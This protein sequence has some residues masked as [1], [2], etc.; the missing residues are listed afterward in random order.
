MSDTVCEGAPAGSMRMDVGLG[1]D[2][3]PEEYRSE[4]ARLMDV[5]RFFALEVNDSNLVVYDR[6]S[7]VRD[8]ALGAWE[9]N[10]C[11]V[12]AVVCSMFLC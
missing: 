9:K 8:T 1:S 7:F 2:W 6:S 4:C 12:K 5:K 11:V 10:M 3:N